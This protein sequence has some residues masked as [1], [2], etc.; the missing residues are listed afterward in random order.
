[1]SVEEGMPSYPTLCVLLRKSDLM[2]SSLLLEKEISTF[3]KQQ[4][5]PQPHSTIQSLYSCCCNKTIVS[6]VSGET[7]FQTTF[8]D[9]LALFSILSEVGS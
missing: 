4:Q 2:V 5:Q 1:M 3:K 9:F 7:I 6:I 8:V